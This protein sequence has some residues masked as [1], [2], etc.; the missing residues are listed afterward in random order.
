LGAQPNKLVAFQASWAAR[1][2]QSEATKLLSAASTTGRLLI[3]KEGAVAVI[4]EGVEIAREGE[5]RAAQCRVRALRGRQGRADGG[6]VITELGL[7]D[8]LAQTG[9]TTEELS[10]FNKF[11]EQPIR[12]DLVVNLTTAKALGLTI[13]EAFLLRADEVIE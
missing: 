1:P 7:A 12:Y 3:L 4:K 2:A 6:K 11:V 8:E 5:R 10:H 13:P 9:L